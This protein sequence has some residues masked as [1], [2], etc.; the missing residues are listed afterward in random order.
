VPAT[1]KPEFPGSH[2]SPNIG[3][4]TPLPHGT[5]TDIVIDFVTETEPL[6]ESVAELV[7]EKL[8]VSD[9]VG[10]G[11]IDAVFESETVI[12]SDKVLECEME[13]ELENEMEFE[14]EFD[15]V[16]DL[17]FDFDFDLVSDRDLVLLRVAPGSIEPNLVLDRDWVRGEIGAPNERLVVLVLDRD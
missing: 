11:V 7:T 14:L 10:R 3:S 13:F 5:V 8:M 12:L 16:P 9:P 1:P 2:C 4:N 6:V 15:F 17:D